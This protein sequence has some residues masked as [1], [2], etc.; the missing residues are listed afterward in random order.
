MGLCAQLV[1]FT[2]YRAFAQL[3]KAGR[4]ARDDSS[5]GGLWRIID[6]GR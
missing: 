2:Q 6:Q 5:E 3:R 4:L 1:M